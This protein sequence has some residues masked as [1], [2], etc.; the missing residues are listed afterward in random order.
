MT[1]TDLYFSKKLKGTIS[2]I[3]PRVEASL[4]NI[5]F[6]LVTEID[7]QAKLKEKLN[8]H[9]KPYTIL[10]ICNPKFAAEAIEAEEN[11]GIFLPCKVLLKQTGDNEV[12]V[13]VLNPKGPMQVMQN[14]KLNALADTVTNMLKKATDEI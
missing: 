9:I 6:G 2:E 4:M 12:E 14:S 1:T 8:K 3:R 11:I 5:G 10:G 7:M 13:V